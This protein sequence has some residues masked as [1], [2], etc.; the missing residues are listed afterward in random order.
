[1]SSPPE[2]RPVALLNLRRV[3]CIIIQ[4]KFPV[5]VSPTT[6]LSV[7]YGEG[8]WGTLRREESRWLDKAS[9]LNLLRKTHHHVAKR[10]RHSGHKQMEVENLADLGR[11]EREDRNISAQGVVCGDQTT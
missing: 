6:S 1:M 2:G 3:Q 8:R 7:A 11:S 4:L 5:P 10:A 9:A